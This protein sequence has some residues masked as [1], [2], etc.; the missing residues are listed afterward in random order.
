MKVAILSLIYSLC[1]AFALAQNSTQDA[2]DE[3]SKASENISTLQADFTQTKKMKM[4]SNAIT[5]K[6]KMWCKQPNLLRWEYLT[7]NKSALILNNGKVLLKGSKHNHTINVNRNKMLRE[8]TRLMIPNGLSKC[9]SE[10]K[11]FLISI[12]PKTII[13]SLRLF[14]K[15]KKS[16]RCLPKLFCTTTVNSL[17]SQKLRCGRR[18]ATVLL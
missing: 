18:M 2:I 11:D 3:I 7:H 4:L 5:S 8:L 14:H 12:E 15:A 13:T 9:L 1:A 16:G 10:K 17:L 6:G